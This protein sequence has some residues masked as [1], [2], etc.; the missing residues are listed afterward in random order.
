MIPIAEPWINDDEIENVLKAMKSGWIARG[1]NISLFESKFANYFGVNYALTVSSGTAA[2][3]VALRVLNLKGKEVITTASSC[4]ATANGIL[5]AGFK[6]VFV[7]IDPITYN[8]DAEQIEDHITSNTGAILAVHI[9]GKP[10]DMKRIQEI[11]EERSITLIEDC[12]QSLGARYNKKLT[13]T[14]GEIAS[15]S[16]YTNKIITTG[17]GG[18]IITNDKKVAEKIK[19]I[20][21]N[22]QDPQKPFYHILYGYNFKMTNIQAAI[23]LAQLKKIE[24]IIKKRRENG[25]YLS[26]LFRGIEEIQ[27]PK[28]LPDRYNVFFCYPILLKKKGI[29]DK[30]CAYLSSKGIETRP[31][32]SSMSTQP[33]FENLF[34]KYQETFSVTENVGKNGFY[35][36][37]SPTLRKEDMK[38]MAD[39]IKKCIVN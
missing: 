20:R 8:M 4:A 32:F 39:T 1:K 3:E 11:A 17:E 9:Y 24:I 27:L 10:C 6:P 37:C 31:M 34:G 18:A 14:F 23:G 35:I 2:L 5:H 26:K 28:E 15:F 33:Y 13:G 19:I 30:V 22:G 16:F 29:R 7:D 25:K 12:A 38:Y 36:S 21:N